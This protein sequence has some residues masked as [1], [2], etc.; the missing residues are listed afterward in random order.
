[1][2]EPEMVAAYI[3]AHGVTVCPPGAVSKNIK[4]K[5]AEDEIFAYWELG[6]WNPGEMP[7]MR[8]PNHSGGSAVLDMREWNDFSDTGHASQ[9][10]DAMKLGHPAMYEL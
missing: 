3:A 9:L 4:F 5:I 1:M 7:E 8:W 2:T 6:G 10:A